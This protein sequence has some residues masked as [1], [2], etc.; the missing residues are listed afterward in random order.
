MFSLHHIQVDRL[1]FLLYV[2]MDNLAVVGGKVPFL[3]HI[4]A[5]NK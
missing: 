3:G 1:V 4:F 5:I 2:A